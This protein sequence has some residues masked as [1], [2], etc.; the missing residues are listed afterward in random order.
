[1]FARLETS[2]REARSVNPDVPLWLSLIVRRLLQRDPAQRF[3]NAGELAA[4][5]K[6]Q[7]LDLSRFLGT[8]ARRMAKRAA[9]VVVLAV[10]SAAVLPN[11]SRLQFSRLEADGKGA[12]VARG[13]DGETLWQRGP[14]DADIAGHY[15]LVHL[16]RRPHALLA[17]VLSGPGDYRLATAQTLS[18]LEPDTGKVVET[19]QLPSAAD[20]FPHYSLHYGLSSIA[21]VDLDGDGI[22]EIV[23]TFQQVPECVSYS[24][25]YEPVMKRARVVF[26]QRGGHHFTGAWDVDG[27]GR[28]DLLFLGINNGYNWVNAIAAVQVTPW[29]GAP[30]G[31]DSD[32]ARA[33]DLV[34]AAPVSPTLLF[35]TLLPRGRMPNDP[36][37][38]SWNAARKTLSIP[39]PD[40][41]VA[42]VH[43][44]FLTADTSPLDTGRRER[45]RREAFLHD[46]ESR[47]LL[48]VGF[49]GQ[50][51]QEGE[52]AVACAQKAADPILAEA[53]ARDLGKTLILTGSAARGEA[54]LRQIA[55][56]SENASEVA[57]DAAM[58][59]HL[60]G[61]VERAVAYYEAGLG[62]GAAAEAGKSKHEFIQGETLALS[63]T[64]E[65]DRSR[66]AIL[67]FSN[68]Y[69]FADDD[70]TAMYREFVRWRTG[71]VPRTEDIRVPLNAT[72]LERYW[73][74]EFRNRRNED[75]RTLLR[76]TEQLLA[77]RNEPLGPLGSLQAVLLARLGRSGEARAAA[78]R[79]LELT[80]QDAKWSI[81]AHSHLALVR[82]RAKSLGAAGSGG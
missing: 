38:V 23:A 79:A 31:I 55:A 29:I 74:L 8:E 48:A 35:Y 33:P 62:H 76:E 68:E 60:R 72:D 73:I 61:D 7:T 17:T 51:V 69:V 46:R 5:L 9:A 30:L 54:L 52:A 34:T 80:L 78:Q 4:A 11:A 50:S 26:L 82:E 3:Q 20:S 43:G 42:A 22:D 39:L 15:A 56:T 19:L 57:Y 66:N 71:G 36:A 1:M 10:L 77:E 47:R 6:G 2:A 18:L 40:G 12:I 64:G 37:A 49:G 67:R 75:A 44:G 58:A 81:I 21:A 41:R 65:W 14:L 28:R 13:L 25:L 24:V 53:M 32:S 59:F 45:W 63:E 27:D 70:W 16:P